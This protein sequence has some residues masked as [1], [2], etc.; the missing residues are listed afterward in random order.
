M[1]FFNNIKEAIGWIINKNAP[2]VEN[3]LFNVLSFKF[4]QIKNSIN[5]IDIKEITKQHC[6]AVEVGSK[7]I[8]EIEYKTADESIRKKIVNIPYADNINAIR[9]PKDEKNANQVKNAIMK[10]IAN[11]VSS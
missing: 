4:L 6:Y 1:L 7:I 8:C 2:N 5:C 11:N 10:A 3:I 9:K